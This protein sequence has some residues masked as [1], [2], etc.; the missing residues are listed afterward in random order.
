MNY[1]STYSHGTIP[2]TVR[3]Y[4]SEENR[5]YTIP[6]MIIGIVSIVSFILSISALLLRQNSKLHTHTRTGTTGYR[7]E[8]KKSKPP[9]QKTG[10][11]R[12]TTITDSPQCKIPRDV[13]GNLPI[14][15]WDSQMEEVGSMV[16]TLKRDLGYIQDQMEVL[17]GNPL[18]GL[19]LFA[20]REKPVDFRVLLDE[21]Q[22]S[23]ISQGQF[24]IE[25]ELM[26]SQSVQSLNWTVQDL[27][28][29]EAKRSETWSSDRRQVLISWVYPSTKLPTVLSRKFSLNLRGLNR[30]E[31]FSGWL[32]ELGS[33]SPTYLHY[34][35]FEVCRLP[36]FIPTDPGTLHE[37]LQSNQSSSET[38]PFV[39]YVSD[40][41][42][43]Y[44]TYYEQ[45]ACAIPKFR[46]LH[47]D[48][49]IIKIEKDLIPVEWALPVSE[50]VYPFWYTCSVTSSSLIFTG[51]Y[52]GI[53]VDEFKF[54]IRE[55][56]T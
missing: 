1:Y 55:W 38:T 15:K 35:E 14:Q 19:V 12:D 9:I 6:A 41:N 32:W 36:W 29:T 27:T 30:V 28:G 43:E 39:L 26:F 25:Y 7:R 31:E 37:E 54:M 49:R 50:S 11:P 52:T 4:F 10:T 44:C 53:L 22:N 56:K 17:Q 2:T 5:V 21:L 40:R 20:L 33:N 34:H 45:L 23:T 24:R 48:V 51:V 18:P 3:H 8:L 13:P 47:R 16:L 46:Q 42:N